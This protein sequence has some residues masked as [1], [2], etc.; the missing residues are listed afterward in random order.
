[1]KPRIKFLLSVQ[2]N[3]NNGPISYTVAPTN[4]TW[5]ED[6]LN[7]HEIEY[8]PCTQLSVSVA[9][10]KPNNSQSHIVI[11]NLQA[12]G[13]KI[14][15]IETGKYTTSSE[16][17]KRIYQAKEKLKSIPYFYKSIAG[18]AFEE[19]SSII[20]RWIMQKV[21][22]NENGQANQCL[23]VFDYIKL[24][25]DNS[26]SKNVAEY[27]A[28]G[29]LMTS[30]HNLCV[31]YQIPC[32][33]FIQLNRDGINREDTDVASGSDRILW[34]CSN[35]S[36]YKRKSEE[37]LAEE[38]VLA[39]GKRYNLK[40][41]PIVSRHGNGLSQGDYINMLGEYEVG[42]IKEG[43]TRNNFHSL[44]NTNSGFSISEE[45]LKDEPID[46]FGSGEN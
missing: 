3:D 13:V 35:F 41:I 34:L 4:R 14:N 29:F 17:K 15:D 26:I 18:Q 36:I 5:I 24:M 25:S 2:V 32:L 39:N 9:M 44:R 12:N 22:V 11:G 30:L 19:T 31:K 7:W 38:E 42:R 16:N 1:M 37:E 20:R 6:D 28:L 8:D 23:I 33:A 27:Q 45:V 40:L 46:F 10:T 43:P 21:G